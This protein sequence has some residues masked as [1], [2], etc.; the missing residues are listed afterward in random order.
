MAVISGPYDAK[1]K[2][3]GVCLYTHMNDGIILVRMHF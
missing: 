2:C 1:N 3:T